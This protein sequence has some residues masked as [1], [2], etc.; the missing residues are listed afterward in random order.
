MKKKEYA[1]EVGMVSAI[2][3]DHMAEALYKKMQE[4]GTGYI[5][6]FEQIANWSIEFVDKHQ[7]TNWED[8]LSG[9]IKPLSKKISSL[10]CWDDAVIDYAFHK[11]E[12]MK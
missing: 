6:T 2:M 4:V 11:L 1:K 3:S 7:K 12:Q 10:I 8:Y 9:D 5:A